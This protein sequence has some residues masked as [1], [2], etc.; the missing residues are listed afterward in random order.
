M[1]DVIWG[2]GADSLTEQ[3]RGPGESVPL[4]NTNR[5]DGVDDQPPGLCA[6]RLWDRLVAET[7]PL[8][9]PHRKREKRR[10]NGR[11]PVRVHPSIHSFIRTKFEYRRIRSCLHVHIERIL[12][13]TFS[14]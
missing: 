10:R 6:L 5:L 1:F 3:P 11:H 14:T 8:L 7:V 4:T 9:D 12:S 13:S 2:K